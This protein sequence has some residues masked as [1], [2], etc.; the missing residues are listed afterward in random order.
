MQKRTKKFVGTCVFAL[1]A[2]AAVLAQQFEYPQT[3]KTD[4]VDTYHGVVVAD[5]YR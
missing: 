5:P 2:S 3:R 1:V 4:H